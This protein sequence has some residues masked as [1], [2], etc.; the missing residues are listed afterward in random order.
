MQSTL[1]CSFPECGRPRHSRDL[2]DAHRTQLRRGGN[3]RPVM[4]RTSPLSVRFEREIDRSGDCWEWTG[5]RTAAG[6]GRIG[7]DGREVYAHVFAYESARGPV[8]A[9]MVV[10]HKWPEPRLCP[11]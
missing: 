1:P 11:S 10:D 6:Y 8:P 2:C 7:T 5:S 3:L 9:G 4:D